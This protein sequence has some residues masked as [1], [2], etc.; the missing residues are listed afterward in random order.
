[1]VMNMRIIFCTV[2]SLFLFFY[3]SSIPESP[4]MGGVNLLKTYA[5]IALTDTCSLEVASTPNG[6]AHHASGANLIR[7][8]SF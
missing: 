3:P 6:K 1:M 5:R 2:P 4:E 7:F 8:L